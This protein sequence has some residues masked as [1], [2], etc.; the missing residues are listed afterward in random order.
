MLSLSWLISPDN[1]EFWDFAKLVDGWIVTL[2]V[3]GEGIAHFP[4]KWLPSA[5]RSEFVQ[6]K[7]G[8]CSWLVLAAAL[9]GEIPIENARDAIAA[10]RD[11]IAASKMAA[12]QTTVAPRQLTLDQQREIARKMRVLATIPGDQHLVQRVIIFSGI[13]KEQRDLKK[14]IIDTLGP[15]GAGWRISLGGYVRGSNGGN[16]SVGI[17]I[18]PASTR[19]SNEVAHALKDA[20]SLAGLDVQAIP[21]FTGEE[22]TSDLDTCTTIWVEVEDK[23]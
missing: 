2:S 18:S 1:S 8:V 10:K 23:P 14:Q 3:I 17:A 11:A 4:Q 13:L 16:N 15:E 7:I 20:L 22:C 12:L 6:N 5:I 19:R 9:A 21:D